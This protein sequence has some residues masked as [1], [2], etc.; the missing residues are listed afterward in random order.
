M[1]KSWYSL[2]VSLN[3]SA[4]SS[5]NIFAL[6]FQSEPEADV[7]ILGV[8][9]NIDES[10]QLQIETRWNMEVPR[11]VALALKDRV[12]EITATLNVKEMMS[13]QADAAYEM[14]SNAQVYLQRASEYLQ[15]QGQVIIYN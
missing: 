12:P 15:E 3:A 14:A 9:M 1:F 5:N 7:D 8:E 11:E 10:N 2:S 4:A 6:H 13:E